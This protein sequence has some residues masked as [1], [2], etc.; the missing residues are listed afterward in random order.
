VNYS[1]D[2]PDLQKTPQKMQSKRN[3]FQEIAP[4]KPTMTA[5]TRTRL[6]TTLL[7][8]TLLAPAVA[9][10]QPPSGGTPPPPPD[11]SAAPIVRSG[12]HQGG[13]PNSDMR[14]GGGFRGGPMSPGSGILPGGMWWKDPATISALSLTD[15]QQK[16]MDT[17]FQDSRLHL[18]DL[19]ANL[20][21]QQVLLQPMLD[22]NPPETNKVMAQIDHV[23]QARAELEKANA[24][25]LLGIRGVLTADQWTKLQATRGS[26]RSFKGNGSSGSPG[27]PPPPAQ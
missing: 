11:G 16:K 25:M 14:R 23:A 5:R 3:N 22:A 18:I 6:L 2:T 19:K 17:I 4:N 7:A 27:A 9:F 20:D 15:E 24:R 10:A 21:K 1:H 13:S 8:A 26:H 12:P